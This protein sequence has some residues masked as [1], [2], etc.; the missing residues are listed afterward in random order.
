MFKEGSV[1]NIT[2]NNKEYLEF[3]DFIEE[4]IAKYFKRIGR[5]EKQIRRRD[6]KYQIFT[7]KKIIGKVEIMS[8]N[9]KTYLFSF[10]YN[11][12]TKKGQILKRN[13]YVY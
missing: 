11:P 4:K 12:L 8:F 2:T 5:L 7:N 3:D 6:F 13:K 10:S 1:L 9:E